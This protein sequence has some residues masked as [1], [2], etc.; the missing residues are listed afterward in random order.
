VLERLAGAVGRWTARDPEWHR[1]VVS[2]AVETLIRRVIRGAASA[3]AALGTTEPVPPWRCVPA[4]ALL[5]W[6]RLGAA[7]PA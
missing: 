3:G 5:V 1:G 6:P 2:G 7:G 4:S